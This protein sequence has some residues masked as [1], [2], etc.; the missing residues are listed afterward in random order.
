MRGMRRRTG[1]AVV[2]EP[3]TLREKPA[4]AGFVVGGAAKPAHRQRENRPRMFVVLG[5]GTAARINEKAGIAGL[6]L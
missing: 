2:I 6:F 4:Q 5:G 1:V 3:L